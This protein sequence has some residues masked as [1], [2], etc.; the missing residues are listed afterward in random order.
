M[1]CKTT[2]CDDLAIGKLDICMSCLEDEAESN[3]HYNDVYEEYMTT[4]RYADLTQ[5]GIYD[6]EPDEP[7]M[8]YGPDKSDLD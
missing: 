1:Q 7:G 3:D 2:G 8:D 4:D 6:R 5:P